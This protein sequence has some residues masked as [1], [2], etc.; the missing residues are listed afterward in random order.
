MKPGNKSF[1]TINGFLPSQGSSRGSAQ[2]HSR[3]TE[4]FERHS[5]FD[6]ADELFVE[7][8]LGQHCDI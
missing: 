7:P 8:F 5:C 1:S 4:N 3:I 2:A 6:A